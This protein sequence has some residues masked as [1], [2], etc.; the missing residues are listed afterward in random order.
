[1]PVDIFGAGSKGQKIGVNENYVD[2]KFVTLT[3]L[4]FGYICA[5]C[6]ELRYTCLALKLRQTLNY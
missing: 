3:K 4:I 6:I 2:S 5:V 1:M